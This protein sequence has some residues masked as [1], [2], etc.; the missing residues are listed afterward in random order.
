VTRIQ[1][2]FV[3][4]PHLTDGVVVLDA[5]LPADVPSHLVGEDE[6]SVRWLTEGQRSTAA[7]TQIWI[8]RSLAAWATGTHLQRPMALRDGASGNL[9]GMAE[10]NLDSAGCGLVA[11]EVN[12]SYQVYPD[13]RGRGFA[14]R[15]LALLV[16][17]LGSVPGVTSA[18]LRVAPGNKPSVRVAAKAGFTEGGW[19][20]T[21]D[22]EVLCVFRRSVL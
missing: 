10:Y 6:E 8:E 3:V 16:E 17:H 11:G 21:P 19:M 15:A 18:V 20:T 4:V 7:S 1:P 12:V 9:A 2:S 5:L 13:Y 14:V 22:G